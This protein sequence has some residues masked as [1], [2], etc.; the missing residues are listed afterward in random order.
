MTMDGR[1]LGLNGSSTFTDK[2]ATPGCL[3][4]LHLCTAPSHS[5]STRFATS[6]IRLLSLEHWCMPQIIRNDK[7]PNGRSAK[8]AVLHGRNGSI[9]CSHRYV[10]QVA[11]H[12]VFDFEEA[13]AV[14]KAGFEFDRHDQA[15]G[16]VQEL[17]GDSDGG[18]HALE[19]K[20]IFLGK[21]IRLTG[22][23]LLGNEG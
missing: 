14:R 16:F 1:L 8:I 18:D 20:V 15:L 5:Q 17:D 13:S 19:A 6:A 22:V 21:L 4:S 7:E 23:V 12:A 11:V 2:M 3:H 9:P 10:C